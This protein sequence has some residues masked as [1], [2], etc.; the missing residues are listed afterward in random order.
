LVFTGITGIMRATFP[1][2]RPVMTA[3]LSRRDLILAGVG[4]AIA[5]AGGGFPSVVFAQASV[6]VEQF[7]ALSEK[8]TGTK[9][10]GTDVARTLLGGF[11]ATGHGAGLAELVKEGADFTSYTELASA[12]VAAWYSGL[13][14]SG[15]GQAVATFTDALVWDALTFTKPWAECGGQTGYWSEPPQD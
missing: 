1:H 12:V 4:A 5:A 6:S 11:L 8:L 9:N 13:Y 10:L 3:S 2:G 14:D 15:S 7:L